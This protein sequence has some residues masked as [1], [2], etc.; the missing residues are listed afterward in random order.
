VDT[1]QQLRVEGEAILFGFPSTRAVLSIRPRPR[2]W[3][4]SGA[5][6][7]M[8]GG[9]VMAGVM[10]IVPPHAPWIMGWL[11]IGGV[12]A[13]R[14]WIER[15]TLQGLDAECPKCGAPLSVKPSRLRLPHPVS[16]EACHHETRLTFREGVLPA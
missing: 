13:R 9:F 3:R 4:A 11:V 1:S 10:A 2:A 8:G 15:Y 6:V 12:M 7:R 5:A 16:C 14:R